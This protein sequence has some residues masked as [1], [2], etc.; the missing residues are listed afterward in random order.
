MNAVPSV[1]AELL[2]L[3]SELPVQGDWKA[4]HDWEWEEEPIAYVHPAS[5]DD[6][7]GHSAIITT[8]DGDFR[9]VE[10]VSSENGIRRFD[11]AGQAITRYIA[12]LHNALP[13]LAKALEGKAQGV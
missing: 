3:R 4:N 6:D 9:N 10:E 7:G 13:E 11:R 12:A 1:I 5:E 2:R 8:S